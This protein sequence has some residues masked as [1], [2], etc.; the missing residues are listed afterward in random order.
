MTRRFRAGLVVEKVGREHLILCQHSGEVHRLLPDFHDTVEA[1]ASGQNVSQFTRQLSALDELGLLDADTPKA[2]TRRQAVAG[3]AGLIGAGVVSL[4]LPTAAQASSLT[5]F[6]NN[7]VFNWRRP[8]GSADEISLYNKFLDLDADIF[9]DGSAWRLTAV[10][11][12]GASIGTATA[13][14]GDV[15]AGELVF[16]LSA[17]EPLV[18]N[19]DTLRGTLSGPRGLT[20]NPFDIF[21][22]F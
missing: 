17:P 15:S 2:P 7:S 9:T 5:L 14:V 4:A 19:G 13:E 12:D 20:S 10:T 8:D 3:F 22:Q 6:D 21:S 11:Q 16:V 18:E 1:L